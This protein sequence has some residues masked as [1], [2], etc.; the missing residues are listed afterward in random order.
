MNV[1]NILSAFLCFCLLFVCRIKI[2]YNSL[3]L[4]DC[5]YCIVL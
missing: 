3:I 4:E 1:A 5:M 2:Q